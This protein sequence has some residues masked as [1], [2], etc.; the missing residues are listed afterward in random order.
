MAVGAIE[1]WLRLLEQNAQKRGV[2]VDTDIEGRVFH[3]H[4]GKDPGVIGKVRYSEEKERNFENEQ[5]I[6]HI[7]HRY[8]RELERIQEGSDRKVVNITLDVWDKSSFDPDERH[9]LFLTQEM[10]DADTYSKGDQKIWIH[11]DGD[12]RGP[13]GTY[14]DDWNVIFDYATEDTIELTSSD[15]NE[16][17]TVSRESK[18]K[19]GR[20]RESIRRDVRVSNKFKNAALDRFDNRCVLTGIEHL[21]LL[22]VSHILDRATHP[23]IAEDLGNVL[24]LNWTHHVA[25]DEDLWTF[26][27]SGRIWIRPDLESNSQY[28]NSSL[29][30]RHGAKIKALTK[31]DSE[32]IER[33]N[34]QLEWWPPR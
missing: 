22:T 18:D 23:E 25:F 1:D 17:S 12:Y 14:V 4:L 8:N 11:G 10:I 27:E 15:E 16:R 13:L 24:I 29:I 5:G 9:F 2:Y 20:V 6:T 33:H 19:S 34:E 28:L 31:V 7:W 26:D 3:F 30:D 21:E 32:Y